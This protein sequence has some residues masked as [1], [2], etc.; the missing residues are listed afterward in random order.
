MPKQRIT[1]EMV[2][3]AA[4]ELAREGGMEKVLVKN[5]AGRLGCSVQPIY[6]YC[7]NMEELKRDVQRRTAVFF[8]E[9]VAAHIKKEDYFHSIGKAYLCLSKEEPNLFEL[10]FLQKRADCAAK[11]LWELYEQECTPAV[12]DFLAETFSISV[13]AARKLHLNMVIYN[14][15]IST[16][17]ISS[18]FGIP[19]EELDRQLV[20]AYEIFLE[21]AVKESKQK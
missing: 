15:G 21:Q 12:A 19:M 14:T 2:V 7:S 17:L 6:S 18:N 9:Y 4:F 5:I 3:E 16:I 11:S 8:Q 20:A 1:K 10:Y 13:E